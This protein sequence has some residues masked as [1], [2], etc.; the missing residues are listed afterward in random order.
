MLK[1]D[2]GRARDLSQIKPYRKIQLGEV[3]IF[4]IG[5]ISEGAKSAY[6]IFTY[7][8]ELTLQNKNP[9]AYTN[10]RKRVKRLEILRLIEVE[11][12]HKRNAIRYRLTPYGLFQRLLLSIEPFEN[13]PI[14]ILAKG[15]KESAILQTVLYQYFNE[16]TVKA[17]VESWLSKHLADYLRESCEAIAR[18]LDDWRSIPYNDDMPM[19]IDEVIS[20]K[21]QNFIYQ[22]VLSLQTGGFTK[23]H[24]KTDGSPANGFDNIQ[25]RLDLEGKKAGYILPHVALEDIGD[26]DGDEDI[27]R[28]LAEDK[29]FIELLGKMKKEFDAGCE[30]FL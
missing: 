2:T 9:M 7:L 11:K 15:M 30:T 3:E 29:R 25:Q 14:I 23:Y 13:T 17:F 5:L 8:R 20:I 10:V 1:L 12:K 21:I 19:A 4:F 22:I 27:A 28:V 26:E 6:D 24:I 18:K 16:E